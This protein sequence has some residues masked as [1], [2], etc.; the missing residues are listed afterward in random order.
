MT[1]QEF[2][3]GYARRSEITV[4]RFYELGLDA[5]PC[6]CGEE[7]CGGWQAQTSDRKTRQEEM[8]QV[9]LSHA[10]DECLYPNRGCGFL[11][12]SYCVSGEDAYECLMKRLTELGVVIKVEGE[13]PKRLCDPG[14][15]DALQGIG[16]E[17]AKRDMLK[18]GY[19]AVEPLIAEGKDGKD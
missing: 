2:I 16:Y 14:L 15:N 9:I 1:K 5:Y 12:G 19:V 11:K 7:G 10:D 4:A 18:A 13:L 8:K 3:E 17:E 6:D